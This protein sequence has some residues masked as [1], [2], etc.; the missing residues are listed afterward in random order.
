MNGSG[1][2]VGITGRL[3]WIVIPYGIGFDHPREIGRALLAWKFKLTPE[4][5]KILD[6]LARGFTNIQIGEALNKDLATV[7]NNL[8]LIYEKLHTRNRAKAAAIAA[9]YGLGEEDE[10]GN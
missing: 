8:Y 4:Q 2:V 1:E 5:V 6:L 9:R 3:H 10:R 7:K